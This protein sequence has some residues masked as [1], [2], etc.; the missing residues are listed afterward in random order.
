MRHAETLRQLDPAAE[1]VC[2]SAREVGSS[3]PFSAISLDPPPLAAVVANPAPLHVAVSAWLLENGVPVL[4]EKPLAADVADAEA[5][6]RVA[7][8]RRVPLMVGYL[9]RF[10]APLRALKAEVDGGAVGRP[11]YLRAE[12]GQ[13]LATWRPGRDVTETVS[14]RADLGGGALLE[15]SHEFDYAVWIM[16]S[17]T[18]VVAM[19]T[20]LGE[21]ASQVE[22]L[23]EVTLAFDSGAVGS[24]HLDM[25]QR[26]PIRVCRVFGTEGSAELDFLSGELRIR[27]AG[28]E[29][30]AIASG[31]S[32]P[33]AEL[34]LAQMR[35]FLHCLESGD[36]P[37][38]EPEAALMA[39]RV[40]AAA[41]R[42]ASDGRR[43]PVRGPY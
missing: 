5:L 42:A 28:G 13:A 6:V 3:P 27:R 2:L 11:L 40:A 34:H 43:V 7:R 36:S 35:H 16:G 1:V 32:T 15:L 41:R 17:P 33:V 18:S 21:P 24:V 25:L 8:E 14:A 19:S 12:V 39:L 37:E 4:V 31:P 38:T 22:D 29:W 9:L 26:D 10:F 23:A 20:Q 30:R